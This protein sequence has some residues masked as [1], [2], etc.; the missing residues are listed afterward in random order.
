M[1]SVFSMPRISLEIV[2]YIISGIVAFTFDFAVF[3]TGTEYLGL[4]YLLANFLGFL[5]GLATAYSMNILWVFSRRRYRQRVGTEFT[6]FIVIVA[7]G[8]GLSQAGMWIFVGVLGLNLVTAKILVSFFVMVFNYATK[9]LILFR[10]EQ[11]VEAT[12]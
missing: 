2:R 7:L 3:Y 6:I 8:L 9:K 5:V 12:N 11:H 1:F 10:S 4:H